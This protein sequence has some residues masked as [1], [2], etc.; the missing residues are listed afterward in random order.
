MTSLMIPPL[1]ILQNLDPSMLIWQFFSCSFVGFALVEVFGCEFSLAKI[2]FGVQVLLV[3]I[4][5]IEMFYLI[6]H[7]CGSP[8][9]L[10]IK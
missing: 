10:L 7:V 5:R 9:Y 4:R 2:L 6:K 8:L 1:H 3:R